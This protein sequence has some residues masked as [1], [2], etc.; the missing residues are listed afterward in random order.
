LLRLVQELKDFYEL[1]LEKGQTLNWSNRDTYNI[2]LKSMIKILALYFYFPLVIESKNKETSIHD[3]LEDFITNLLERKENT[4]FDEYLNT[5]PVFKLTSSESTIITQIPEKNW[6]KI[7]LKLKEYIF[8]P[9]ETFQTISEANDTITPELLSFFVEIVLNEYEKDFIL[10]SKVS[11]RKRKGAFYSPWP[12]IT[13]LVNSVITERNK[14]LTILDPS[15]GTGSFLIYAAER[16]YQMNI[17]SNDN[18]DS[19]RLNILKNYIYG[20]DNSSS[21]ILVTKIRLA[22]WG[23]TTSIKNQLKNN[24]IQWN[25]IKLGNSL[26]GFVSE[27]EPPRNNLYSSFLHILEKKQDPDYWSI[28]QSLSEANFFAIY[29]QIISGTLDDHNIIKN[30]DLINKIKSNLKDILDCTYLGETIW[31]SIR[32]LHNNSPE[33][34]YYQLKPFHWGISFPNI[35]LNGGFDVTVGNPPYGRSVLS[36]AEKNLAKK[37]YNSC[38]G[39]NAKKISLNSA[40]LFLERSVNLLKKN[41]KLAFILPF[42]FLRV[43]EFEQ[44]REY[45]LKNTLITTIFDESSAFQDVTLEMCSI[46]LTKKRID[47]YKISIVPRTGLGSKR[48]I[49]NT[50]FKKFK[51]FMLYYDSLWRNVAEGSKFS[52]ILADYGLDHRIVKKDLRKDYFPT[53]KYIIPFLHSGRSVNK[54]CLRP[55]F[56]HWSHIDHD[57]PRFKLYLEK[58]KLICTAIGNE[59][60][61]SYKPRKMI[62]GTNVSIMEITTPNHN[63]FPYLLILNSTMASYILKRYILNYSNLTVYLHKYYTKL[64]PIKYPLEYEKEW[65]NLAQYTSIL[66]QINILRK[67]ISY[68]K[69]LSLLQDI[70]NYFVFQLYFNEELGNIENNIKDLMKTYLTHLQFDKI[71][72]ELLQPHHM[73]GYSK[74]IFPD[75]ISR[76][77]RLIVDRVGKLRE[78]GMVS[79]LLNQRSIYLKSPFIKTILQDSSP[80]M[81][82][83]D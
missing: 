69:Q 60:R 71:F 1:I 74:N 18:D 2:A 33:E 51:R 30:K 80:R 40:S 48:D 47:Y 5:F 14:L 54:F 55:T 29:N 61:V 8:S 67:D 19:L 15:C 56:F 13:R 59:F 66:A 83:V 49:R 6:K 25:N 77:E 78:N 64:I 41:G 65:I 50:V 72:E 16:L 62:P 23:L 9:F 70:G 21:S 37:L 73:Q 57:N 31:N 12:I 39:K 26:F 42:S 79:E 53:D 17:S 58:P 81:I 34:K 82:R 4:Q 3:L 46:V 52:V 32:S 35:F 45:I 63:L 75:L 76:N 10:H 22:T 38:R 7:L 36:P 27:Q 20:V 24:E 28:R 44:I 11:R 68:E 43:E